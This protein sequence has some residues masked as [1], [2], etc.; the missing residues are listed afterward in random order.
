MKIALYIEDGLEQIV[1]TPQSD[2]EKRILAKMHDDRRKLDLF[3]GSFF[4]CRA[5]FVRQGTSDEYEST[6]IVLRLPAPA[7]EQGGG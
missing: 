5:G 6:I 2:A 3:R 7:P 1:L 4:E